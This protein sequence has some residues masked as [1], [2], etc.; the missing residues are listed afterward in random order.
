MSRDPCSVIC[1]K[2]DPSLSATADSSG[3]ESLAG[4]L[5]NRNWTTPLVFC[6]CCI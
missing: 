4:F 5:V 3:Q 1:G 6:K 2:R